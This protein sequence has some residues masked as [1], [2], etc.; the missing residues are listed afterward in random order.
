MEVPLALLLSNT[1]ETIN[2]QAIIEKYNK[3]YTC[4][5]H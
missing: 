1:K 5:G 2:T 4:V 3:P